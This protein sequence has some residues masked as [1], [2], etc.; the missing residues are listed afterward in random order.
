MT[1]KRLRD[2]RTMQGLAV[3]SVASVVRSILARHGWA[4]SEIAMVLD[5]VAAVAGVW[6]GIGLYRAIERS[7]PQ[8]DYIVRGR[9]P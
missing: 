2:S 4:E 6:G 8:G 9:E 1:P 3:A 7:G 5:L